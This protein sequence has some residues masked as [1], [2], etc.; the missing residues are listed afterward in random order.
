MSARKVLLVA[1]GSACVGLGVLGM[2][3]PVLPT[4]PFLLLAACCYARGSQRFYRWLVTNRWCGVYIRNYREGRGMLLWHKI[5]ALVLLW[6]TIGNT[7][8]FA[9]SRPW[10]RLLLFGI[11]TGV[12]IHLWRIRTCRPETSFGTIPA[13]S[14]A[15]RSCGNASAP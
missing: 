8:V 7:V 12:T 6:L 13:P 9:V 3:L 4:T 2:I 1:G 11:A 5:A 10:L 15:K 14:A